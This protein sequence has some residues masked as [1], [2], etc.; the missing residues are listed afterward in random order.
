MLHINNVG[1][2]PPAPLTNVTSS[3]Q[4]AF[5]ET[6]TSHK[7]IFLAEIYTFVSL[8]VSLKHNIETDRQTEGD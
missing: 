7:R 8:I 2:G 3:F 5:P 4:L 6:T 1:F